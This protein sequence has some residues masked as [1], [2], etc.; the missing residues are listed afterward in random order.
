MAV[1]SQTS[2]VLPL[3]RVIVDISHLS[4][5]ERNGNERTQ[6]KIYGVFLGT[7]SDYRLHSKDQQRDTGN[8]RHNSRVLSPACP[9]RTISA[10][11]GRAYGGESR[12]AVRPVLW[13]H[14]LSAP[15]AGQ[16][17]GKPVE[18]RTDC[19]HPSAQFVPIMQHAIGSK[20]APMK[21][22]K[23]VFGPVFRLAN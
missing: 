4:S 11:Y 10:A 16:R 5:E 22:Q 19:L 3:A 12:Y 9:N 17:S 23:Q 13:F 18:V 1:S 6:A 21:P 2:Q 15:Q 20:P 14:S 8:P 7:G